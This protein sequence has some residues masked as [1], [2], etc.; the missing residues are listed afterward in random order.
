MIAYLLALTMQS[1]VRYTDWR[2]RRIARHVR[3]RARHRCQ[4][5]GRRTVLHVHHLRPVS[6]GG[7]HSPR[8]LVAICVACHEQVHGRDLDR[9]GRVGR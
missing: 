8:N 7:G 1:G 3:S 4:W 5:C 2:W 6:R 9:D